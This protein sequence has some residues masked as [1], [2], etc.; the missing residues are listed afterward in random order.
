MT[1]K[2]KDEK[3]TMETKGVQQI[4]K[5]HFM[6][7]ALFSIPGKVFNKIPLTK[8]QEKTEVISSDISSNIG[9]VQIMVDAIFI[10]RK[11][12]KNEGYTSTF[13][14][15]LRLYNADTPNRYLRLRKYGP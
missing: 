6:K 5:N 15:K 10:N 9:L 3:K 2:N 8:I 14:L 7:F 13:T 12:P 1:V 4:W 11:N